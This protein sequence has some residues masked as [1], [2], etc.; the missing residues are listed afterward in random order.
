MMWERACRRSAP[1]TGSRPFDVPGYVK[2]R[3]TSRARWLIA[4]AAMLV[5]IAACTPGGSGGGDGGPTIPTGPSAP[6]GYGY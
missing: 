3:R 6:G 1:E 2:T 5:A 4:V